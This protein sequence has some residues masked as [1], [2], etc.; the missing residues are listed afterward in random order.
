MTK[1][2]LYIPGDRENKIALVSP[3]E[4]ATEGRK[5]KENIRE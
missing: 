5:G 2:E 3:F 4:E 1:C